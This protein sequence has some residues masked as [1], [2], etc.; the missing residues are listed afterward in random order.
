MFPDFSVL[1]STEGKICGL[2]CE[3]A[4]I[5]KLR[6]GQQG[7]I[8]LDRTCFYAEGGGQEADSGQ[9]ISEVILGLFFKCH[10]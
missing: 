4:V 2:S 3:G 6:E 9:L 5:D 8:I 1:E 7:E 10:H